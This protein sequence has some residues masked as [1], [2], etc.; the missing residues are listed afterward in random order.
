M[1]P[2]KLLDYLRRRPF[3]PFRLQLA[4][5]GTRDVYHHSDLLLGLG[6]VTYQ[7]EGRTEVIRAEDIT[8]VNPLGDG[9]HD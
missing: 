7:P 2:L 1:H 6:E 8:A 9:V 5:G 4:D 3:I